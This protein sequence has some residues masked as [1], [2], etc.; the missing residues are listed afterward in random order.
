ML[1]SISLRGWFWLTYLTLMSVLYLTVILL[2]I[3]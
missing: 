2:L 1:R 3:L